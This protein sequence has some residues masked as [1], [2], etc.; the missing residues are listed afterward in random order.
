MS[1]TETDPLYKCFTIFVVFLLS[2]EFNDFE[3]DRPA[4]DYFTDNMVFPKVWSLYI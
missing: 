4:N 2:V 1:D 3:S